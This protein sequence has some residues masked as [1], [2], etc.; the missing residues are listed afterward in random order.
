MTSKQICTRNTAKANTG[1]RQ[2][3]FHR[4]KVETAHLRQGR[5]IDFERASRDE[6][7]KSSCQKGDVC[8][9]SR[10]L[11]LRMGKAK[12]GQKDVRTRNR[13]AR[14]K[15]CKVEKSFEESDL[16]VLEGGARM[17]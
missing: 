11:C 8:R 4:D 12:V 9:D 1:T 2:K 5:S 13:L 17:K 3:L 14:E 15:A 7:E 6:S 16:K 10:H